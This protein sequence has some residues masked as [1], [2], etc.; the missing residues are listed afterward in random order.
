MAALQLAFERGTWIVGTSGGAMLM[1]ARSEIVTPELM[2]EISRV[3]EHGALPD[4]DP[5]LPPLIDC[6]G[7]VAHGYCAPHFDRVFPWK[8]LERSLIADSEVLIGID[9]QTALVS[10]GE[11]Q[12]EVRG[13]GGVTLIHADLKPVRYEAGE[14]VM[15]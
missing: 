15:L 2:E 7:W 9:E 3:W 11:G 6:L 1:G 10:R 4:W 5:P 14:H 8:W 13:R 12:W